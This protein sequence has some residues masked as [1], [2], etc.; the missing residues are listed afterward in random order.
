MHQNKERKRLQKPFPARGSSELF[1]RN[2]TFDVARAQSC[3]LLQQGAYDDGLTHQGFERTENRVEVECLPKIA[4]ENFHPNISLDSLSHYSTDEMDDEPIRRRRCKT[5]VLFV[6]QLE[7]SRP[8]EI[9]PAECLAGQYR[10]ELAP[11]AFTPANEPQ[12]AK[13]P[14]RRLRKI[15]C[16]VSLRDIIKEHAKTASISDCETLCGSESPATS[17]S[18]ISPTKSYFEV[19]E[20]KLVDK[21]PRRIFTPDL[22]ALDAAPGQ[23]NIIALQMCKNLLTNALFQDHPKENGDEGS[24]LQIL[25][26]IEAYEAIQQQVRRERCQSNAAG[27]LGDIQAQAIDGILDHWLD[28]LYA[29]YDRSQEQSSCGKIEVSRE[30]AEEAWLGRRSEDSQAT[31][32]TGG[33]A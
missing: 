1:S 25:L 33:W 32:I 17:T 7:N 26:M 20:L 27:Q 24:G 5:P 29:M 10:A 18:T 23:Q 12:L 30:I 9:D 11:R 19:D 28:A 31:C 14:L 21:P 13:S 15:K 4:S 6:G 2:T 22:Q 16:Q 8:L 3:L